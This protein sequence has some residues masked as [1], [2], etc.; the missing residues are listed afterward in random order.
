M[1]AWVVRAMWEK[2]SIFAIMAFFA[3]VMMSSYVKNP[4]G[5][6]VIWGLFIVLCVAMTSFTIYT[7]LHS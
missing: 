6:L 3:L 5:K 4:I 2:L 1:E 7:A